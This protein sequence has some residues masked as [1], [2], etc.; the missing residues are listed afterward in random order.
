[1]VVPTFLHLLDL[2]VVA[3]DK[4]TQFTFETVGLRMVKPASASPL[5]GVEYD[6][7]FNVFA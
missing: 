5:N 4:L 6:V 7:Q 3:V 2:L 1:M